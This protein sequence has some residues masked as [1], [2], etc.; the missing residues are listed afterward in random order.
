M[1]SISKYENTYKERRFQLIQ[2][3]KSKGIR[4]TELLQVM[5]KLPRELFVEKAFINRAYEDNALPIKCE[6]TISQP[7]TV[8][9]M[10]ELLEVQQGEKV[11]EIGTGSGYQAAILFLLGAEVFTIERHKELTLK[12]KEKFSE[13]GLEI[14]SFYGDGSIGLMKYSPYDKI[15]VT[16][17]APE[18]PI[19]LIKQLKLGGRLVVPV[20]DKNL[21]KMHLIIRT[22]EDNYKDYEQDTFRFVP[23]IGVE[24]WIR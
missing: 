14:N 4:D 22:D 15:I 11:L 20:G 24:G 18:I 21:Q 12:A 8:A 7:Y 3:L 1:D 19:S 5:Q 10:T 6:Q 16:A 13:L 2:I 23:L 9:Y 17:A